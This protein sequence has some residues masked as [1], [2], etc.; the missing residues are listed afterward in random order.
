MKTAD[1]IK[2]EIREEILKAFDDE[3][4]YLM[5]EVEKGNLCFSN[6]WDINNICPLFKK[7]FFKLLSDENNQQSPNLT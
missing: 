1:D 7:S 2:L 4:A 5:S 6:D 3:W